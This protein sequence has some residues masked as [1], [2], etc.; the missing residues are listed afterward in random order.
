MLE[1]ETLLLTR[2]DK[3]MGWDV[4]VGQVFLPTRYGYMD[5]GPTGACVPFGGAPA[6][7]YFYSYDGMVAI[8]TDI[9]LALYGTPL[10]GAVRRED[11]STW[12]TISALS[13]E[14][15]FFSQDVGKTIRVF[16]DPNYTNE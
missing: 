11:R 12:Y 13:G 9:N 3:R 7:M 15:F 16:Y 10:T 8:G 5:R 14:N 1:K 6:L 4:T 2:A